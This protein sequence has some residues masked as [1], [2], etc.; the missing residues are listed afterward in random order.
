MF[1]FLYVTLVAAAPAL[2]AAAIGDLPAERPAP[3]AAVEP[4]PGWRH[5][6]AA[7][8][9]IEILVPAD[10]LLE[11]QI[12]LAMVLNPIPVDAEGRPMPVVETPDARP[13]NPPAVCKLDRG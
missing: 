4:A 5:D 8:G 10:R 7:D 1:R 9:T 3:A 13:V 2:A 11:C 6:T 12:T